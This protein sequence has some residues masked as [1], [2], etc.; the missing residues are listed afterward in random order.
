MYSFE[1]LGGLCLPPA[2]LIKIRARE[3]FDQIG[4][5]TIDLGLVVGDL[6]LLCL[7]SLTAL[8]SC[9]DAFCALAGQSIAAKIASNNS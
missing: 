4:D 9:V 1:G 8:T 6:C 5:L 2:R 3:L 7:S